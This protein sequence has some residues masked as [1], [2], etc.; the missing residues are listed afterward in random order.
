M[1][2]LGEAGGIERL[3][4]GGYATVHHVAGSNDIGAGAC[5]RYRRFREP[6]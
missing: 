5:V 1:G 6:F 3:A 2:V 4:D